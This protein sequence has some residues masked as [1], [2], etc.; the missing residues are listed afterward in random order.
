MTNAQRREL[1]KE[2]RMGWAYRSLV[3][4][5]EAVRLTEHT[6]TVATRTALDIIHAYPYIPAIDLHHNPTLCLLA[7]IWNAGRIQGIREERRLRK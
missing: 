1:R 6:T 3:P 2:Y 4:P 7:C 5:E